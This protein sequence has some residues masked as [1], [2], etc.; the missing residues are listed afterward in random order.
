MKVKDIKLYKIIGAIAVFGLFGISGFPN[1]IYA[2]D[3]ISSILTFTLMIY[4][5]TYFYCYKQEIIP[6]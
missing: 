2:S 6:K 1:F 3:I 5:S 4:V